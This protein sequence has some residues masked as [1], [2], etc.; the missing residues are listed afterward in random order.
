[1]FNLDITN[2]NNEDRNKNDHI[3]NSLRFRKNLLYSL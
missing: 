1:M 3:F 2:E